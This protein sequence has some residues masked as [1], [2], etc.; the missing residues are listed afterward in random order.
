MTDQFDQY[1]ASYSRIIAEGAR[2]SGE[3]YEYMVDLR[4]T[5]FSR[6]TGEHLAQ[7]DEPALLDFGCGSGYTVEVLQQR[8]PR[9]WLKGYDSSK[10]SIDQARQRNIPRAA[11]E[12]GS[13]CALPFGEDMFDAVYS[14][15]T[16]HHIPGSERSQWIRELYRVLKRRGGLVIFENNPLNP[17]MMQAMR[18]TPFDVDAEPVSAR[19]LVSL[20]RQE[21][22]RTQGGQYY[23]FF[24]R[25]LRWFRRFEP[26]LKRVPFGAQY[27]VKAFK[28]E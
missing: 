4:A 24:P 12:H 21:G 22:F 7:R 25:A 19:R 27:Y 20:L 3:T 17:L 5:L 15:G 10:D 28:P 14:N 2:A 26:L 23:F 1:A 16:F 11:F 18:R 9:A 6:E 8:F 13:D